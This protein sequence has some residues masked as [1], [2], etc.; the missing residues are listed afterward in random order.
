MRLLKLER[1]P[2]PHVVCMTHNDDKLVLEAE[3]TIEK[4][5]KAKGDFTASCRALVSLMPSRAGSLTRIVYASM[6]DHDP[7]ILLEDGS[8]ASR[9]HETH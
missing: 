2:K 9:N 6:P 8:A 7:A 5:G 3:E 4:K 1:S